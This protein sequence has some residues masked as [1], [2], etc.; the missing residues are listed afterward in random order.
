MKN[1][2][3][4]QIYRSLQ[5]SYEILRCVSCLEDVSHTYGLPKA[6]AKRTLSLAVRKDVTMMEVSLEFIALFE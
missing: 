4:V 1:H 5:R 3:Q 6:F 2:E